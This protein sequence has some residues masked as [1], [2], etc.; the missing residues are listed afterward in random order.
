[1]LFK[2]LDSA[3]TLQKVT[4]A[5]AT[6]NV[7]TSFTGGLDNGLSGKSRFGFRAGRALSTGIHWTALGGFAGQ[8]NRT[9]GN[10]QQL[11]IKQ[12][13]QTQL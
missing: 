3:S 1:M 8:S 9:G 12:V 10:G 4:T 7:L 5:G 13:N 6:T 11:V 2:G